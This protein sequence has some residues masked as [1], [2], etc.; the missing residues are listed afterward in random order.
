[1]DYKILL[2]I[3][4]SLIVTAFVLKAI[5][6][7]RIP[8][9]E[10]TTISTVILTIV[11]LTVGAILKMILLMGWIYDET[12]YGN[13]EIE[14]VFLKEKSIYN[15]PLYYAIYLENDE[16]KTIKFEKD[17]VKLYTKKSF[18]GISRI[19]YRLRYN[20]FDQLLEDEGNRV[21]LYLSKDYKI[22][23]F[24][25]ITIDDIKYKRIQRNE[26]INEIRYQ[27]GEYSFYILG[28]YLTEYK[29][30]ETDS[31]KVKIVKGD[32]NGY[33]AC[34]NFDY[35]E[36]LSGELKIVPNFEAKY[37]MIISEDFELSDLK[38]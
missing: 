12:K 7:K 17:K 13:I 8:T 26:C 32:T 3:V 14:K 5:K 18:D 35:Y 34:I 16:I 38:R 10:E 33:K 29:F 23:P 9:F 4:I 11:L 15:K 31:T 6:E 30:K 37:E 1:M 22:E 21:Y 25:H 28:N 20:V 24:R 36:Y 19:E 27:D 2:L